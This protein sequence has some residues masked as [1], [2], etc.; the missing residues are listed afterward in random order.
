MQVGPRVDNPTNPPT[1]RRCGG[2]R[3]TTTLPLA[4]AARR[5]ASGQGTPAVHQLT[6]D[7]GSTFPGGPLPALSIRNEPGQHHPQRPIL[8]PGQQRPEGGDALEDPD[9]PGRDGLDPQSCL[10]RGRQ[11]HHRAV[12]KLLERS[13]RQTSGTSQPGCWKGGKDPKRRRL[14]PRDQRVDRDLGQLLPS[15]VGQSL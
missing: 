1:T 15:R 6:L 12:P 13:V 14:Q 4:L 8:G 3:P 2:S 7:R 10:P 9:S 5:Q 11:R